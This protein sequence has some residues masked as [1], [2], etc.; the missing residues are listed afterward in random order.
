MTSVNVIA[1]HLDAL[2][3]RIKGRTNES[4]EALLNDLV[5]QLV[6]ALAA[7]AGRAGI[8]LRGQ[9][10]EGNIGRPDFSVKE[11]LLL[12]GHVETKAPGAGADSSK[13]KGHDK[14]QWTRFQAAS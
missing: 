1:D 11:N 9:A 10:Y 6:K 5:P 8:D 14:D 7:E 3:K 2:R 12:I 13:F 4:P